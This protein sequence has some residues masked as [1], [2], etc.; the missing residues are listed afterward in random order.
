MH[1]HNRMKMKMKMK[2]SE[3]EKDNGNQSYNSIKP[4][5]FRINDRDDAG[6]Y[7]GKER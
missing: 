1:N 2:M 4:V 3:N 5:Q 6:Y 7:Y